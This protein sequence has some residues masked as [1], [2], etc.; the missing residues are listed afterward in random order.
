MPCSS[1][2]FNV[3]FFKITA[4]LVVVGEVVKLGEFRPGI[5]EP[6]QDTSKK[7]RIGS[8]IHTYIN[9]NKL[10]GEYIYDHLEFG[11]I[12]RRK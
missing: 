4:V 7:E 9:M 11:F 6:I 12:R 8:I 1:T 2:F 10:Y 3:E 5:H